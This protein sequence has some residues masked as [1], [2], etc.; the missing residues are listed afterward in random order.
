MALP[1]ELTKSPVVT[2]TIDGWSSRRLISMIGIIVHYYAESVSKV[3]VLSLEM[4]NGPHTAQRI[5]R[6]TLNTC[7]HWNIKDKIARIGTD[8]GSNM[9]KAFFSSKN[10]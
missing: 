6:F 2:I 3:S 7:D 5:A 8:N 4:I 10:P 1:K 9:V